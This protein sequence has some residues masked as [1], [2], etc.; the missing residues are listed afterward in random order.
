M[1]GDLFE[2][3]DLVRLRSGLHG[4]VISVE[5]VGAKNFVGRGG[6]VDLVEVMTDRGDVGKVLSHQLK[7][8][9]DAAIPKR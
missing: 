5:P 4:I 2:V 7:E 1:S 8:W 6:T 9:K 3:G